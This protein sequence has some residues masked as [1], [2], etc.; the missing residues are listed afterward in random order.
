MKITLSPLSTRN[1]LHIC[2]YLLGYLE[3]KLCVCFEQ[4]CGP[5]GKEH[6]VKNSKRCLN[7]IFCLYDNDEFSYVTISFYIINDFTQEYKLHSWKE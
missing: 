7:D 1:G 3:L 2:Y 6:I 5:E 4:M